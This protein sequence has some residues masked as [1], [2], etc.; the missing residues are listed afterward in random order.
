M[1]ENHVKENRCIFERLQGRFGSTRQF[2]Y[3]KDL[4]RFGTGPEL[5]QNLISFPL[6]PS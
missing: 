6:T 3:K 5:L 4:C 1:A 2:Q